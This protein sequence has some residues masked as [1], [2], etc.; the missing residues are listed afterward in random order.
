MIALQSVPPPPP[1][2]LG[3][4]LMYKN[5]NYAMECDEQRKMMDGERDRGLKLPPFYTL[6]S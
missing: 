2:R 1:P 3:L 5:L 6:Y 4:G